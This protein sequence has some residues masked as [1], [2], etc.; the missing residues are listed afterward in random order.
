MSKL[1]DFLKQVEEVATAVETDAFKLLKGIVHLVEVGAPIA[2][3]VGSAIGNPEVT[4]VAKLARSTAQGVDT[5][6]R[7]GESATIG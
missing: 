3:V 5:V 4:E 7:T 1:T 6:I 2:E